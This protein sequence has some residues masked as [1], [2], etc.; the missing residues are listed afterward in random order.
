MELPGLSFHPGID[1]QDV[2]KSKFGCSASPI[3][4]NRAFFLV[5]SFGRYKLCLSPESVGFILQATLG[6]ITAD[7][8][9]L[10]LSDR[11]FRFSVSSRLVGFHIFKR[12]SFVCSAF[13]VFFHLWSN[14]GPNCSVNGIYFSKRRKQLRP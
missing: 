10:A 3:T 13:K 4:P 5:A 8:S 6:G 2:I 14:G 12:P 11:V 7:L 9:V 1:V